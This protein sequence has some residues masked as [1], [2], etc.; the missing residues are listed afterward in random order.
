MDAEPGTREGAELDV[1]V[2]LVELY[3]ARHVRM[4]YT[5]FM[6]ASLFLLYEAAGIF[7]NLGGGWLATRFGIPRMLATGLVLQITGLMLLSLLDPT[8]GVTP[9]VAWAVIAQ[10]ISGVAKDVHQDR[11]EVRNQGH[12]RGRQ[13]RALQMGGVVHRFE[14]CD[15]RV[16]VL[17]RRPVAGDRGLQ[18]GAL[19]DGGD[20]RGGAG[21]CSPQPAAR[22]RQGKGI[23]ELR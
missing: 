15:E 23:E 2:D 10:G 6:L 13:R 7:A 1:L 22:A 19:P 11:F 3:E 4:G 17:C 20:A 5:P 12:V 14:E 18:A 21:Q 16:R 8:W 9:S